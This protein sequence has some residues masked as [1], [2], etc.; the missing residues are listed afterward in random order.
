MS[1]YFIRAP[2]NDELYHFGIK[3]MKWGVRRFRNKDGSYT[4]AGLKRY[5]KKR[6]APSHEHL[7]RSRDADEIYK[8]RK[9]YT[10]QELQGRL[11]RL[12]TEENIYRKTRKSKVKNELRNAGKWALRTAFTAGPAAYA[13][14][15]IYKHRGDTPSYTFGKG[16]NE[17][18]YT[19][20]EW[21]RKNM[22]DAGKAAFGGKKK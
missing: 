17:T 21:M 12:N 6:G 18:H 2:M 10:D 16:D 7:L 9:Y 13:A 5:K 20:Q 8:Y 19:W 4:S 3:G 11:N 1:T 14:Y 15:N 22:F